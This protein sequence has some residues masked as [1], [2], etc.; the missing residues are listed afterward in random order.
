V[1]K[2][3]LCIQ[4][5]VHRGLTL[6]QRDAKATAPDVFLNIAVA[7]WHFFGR[8]WDFWN[9]PTGY[10]MT[11]PEV[12]VSGWFLGENV[13]N[14]MTIELKGT[15]HQY[16]VAAF[17]SRMPKSS[18]LVA[19]SPCAK[20]DPRSTGNHNDG[21][22]SGSTRIRNIAGEISQESTYCLGR[23]TGWAVSQYC[24]TSGWMRN[25]RWLPVNGSE[26]RIM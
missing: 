23:K 4:V 8:N 21:H 18:L 1:P 25:Q 19:I 13:I 12:K 14:L 2:I 24:P 6:T 17:V 3:W 22:A 7:R 15:N 20:F 5:R 16:N 11:S 9:S 26:Y 10:R